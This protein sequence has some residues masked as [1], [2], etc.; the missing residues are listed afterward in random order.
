M[1][2]LD[3]HTDLQT[4]EYKVHIYMIISISLQNLVVSKMSHFTTSFLKFGYLELF[5]FI[6]IMFYCAY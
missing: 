1:S 4:Y 6:E 2:N 3:T 5:I